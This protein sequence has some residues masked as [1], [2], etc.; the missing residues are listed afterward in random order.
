MPVTEKLTYNRT[1]NAYANTQDREEVGR[2]AV[3]FWRSPA[4]RKA[5]LGGRFPPSGV[6]ARV[7][8]TPPLAVA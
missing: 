7:V 5:A 8:R 1:A 4:R 3:R 2:R 6:G